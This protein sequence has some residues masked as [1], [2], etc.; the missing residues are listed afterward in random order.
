MGEMFRD[1]TS[2]KAVS[3]LDVAVKHLTDT[4]LPSLVPEQEFILVRFSRSIVS[5][6]PVAAT[7]ANIKDAIA[8]L[9]DWSP[10]G[11]T[12]IYSALHEAYSDPKTKAVHLISDGDA[13]DHT[14]LI[15]ATRRWCTSHA[16]AFNPTTTN[17]NANTNTN[18][19]GHVTWSW[20]E[21][22]GGTGTSSTNTST[23]DSSSDTSSGDD[24]GGSDGDN[25]SGGDIGGPITS[26]TSKP[27]NNNTA[28]ATASAA[29]PCRVPCHTVCIFSD[30]RSKDLMATLADASDGTF[31]N[32]A[33]DRETYSRVY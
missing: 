33:A 8:K 32:Y 9:Q 10:D 6:D 4:V 3:R 23:S 2:K 16:D 1:R 15:S 18:S 22:G 7:D 5:E 31:K 20:A 17:T 14:E 13:R 27:T 11:S 24:G 19:D 25:E 21:G 26:T 12:E 30:G 29:A 28:A